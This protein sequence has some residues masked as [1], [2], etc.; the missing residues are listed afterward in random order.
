LTHTLKN[1]IDEYESENIE[2][3]I[4]QVD[5]LIAAQRHELGECR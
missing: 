2:K 1:I 4:E 3:K 5:E